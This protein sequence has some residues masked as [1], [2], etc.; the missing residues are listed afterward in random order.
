M[1]RDYKDLLNVEV[2]ELRAL[3]EQRRSMKHEI[4]KINGQLTR[5]REGVLGLAALAGLNIKETN[6]EIFTDDFSANL[7]L[8]Q[9]IRQVLID[10]DMPYTPTEIRDELLEYSFPIDKHKNPLASIHSILKR[11]IDAGHVVAAI[12]VNTKKNVYMAAESYYVQAI[13]SGEE[14]EYVFKNEGEVEE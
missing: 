3:L 6:P 13:A 4:D 2:G 1:T 14:D 7:G 11:L 5:L 10:V 9:A 12:D 8:T